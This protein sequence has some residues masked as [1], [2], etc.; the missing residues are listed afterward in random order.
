MRAKP[1]MTNDEAMRK[2][3]ALL[4]HDRYTVIMSERKRINE[5]T[6]PRYNALFAGLK[7]KYAETGE[8]VVITEF[9]ELFETIRAKFPNGEVLWCLPEEFVL[10]EQEACPYFEKHWTPKKN[11]G[12]DSK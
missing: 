12:G 9:D 1:T 11:T 2:I 10:I 3:K 7:L 6:V 4:A 5:E 8:T